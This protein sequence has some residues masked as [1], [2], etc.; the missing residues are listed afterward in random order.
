MF[1]GL[2]SVL[3][4]LGY[5]NIAFTWYVLIGSCVTFALG[6]AISRLFAQRAATS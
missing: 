3:L 6:A 5:T 1:G 2:A 4:A